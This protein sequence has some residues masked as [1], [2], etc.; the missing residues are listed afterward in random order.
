M[1]FANSL[2]V[3]EGNDNSRFWPGRKSWCH[4][5][6]SYEVFCFLW[7]SGKLNSTSSWYL[8]AS[9]SSHILHHASV[10]LQCRW[11]SQLFFCK[12]NGPWPS[13]PQSNWKGEKTVDAYRTTRKEHKRVPLVPVYV[14]STKFCSFSMFFHETISLWC[15]GLV[16]IFGMPNYLWKSCNNLDVKL[17]PWS[18]KISSSISSMETFH[19]HKA[20]I[21]TGALMLQ[22]GRPL[23]TD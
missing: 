6:W 8:Q 20:R 11:T 15:Y 18:I 12:S 21:T 23:E 16:L 1:L 22:R 7:A 19:R 17:V 14:S 9:S 5:F 4:A 10:T 3:A 2:L 13:Q